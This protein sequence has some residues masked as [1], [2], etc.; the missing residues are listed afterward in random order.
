M[1]RAASTFYSDKIWGAIAPPP[2]IDAP[3]QNMKMC[4]VLDDQSTVGKR[5]NKHLKLFGKVDEPKRT[6]EYEKQMISQEDCLS[7]NLDQ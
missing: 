4:G 5:Q 2:F 6:K 7:G 1:R 3:D